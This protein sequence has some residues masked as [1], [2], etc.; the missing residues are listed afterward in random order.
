MYIRP[1]F[2]N[3]T[4]SYFIQKNKDRLDEN[5]LIDYDA[6]SYIRLM[7]LFETENTEATISFPENKVDQISLNESMNYH[8]HLRFYLPKNIISTVGKKINRIVIMF[9]G[10]NELEYFDFF[11]MIGEYFANNNVAAVLLPTPLNLNRRIKEDF[12]KRKILNSKFPTIRAKEGNE[13]LFFYS[14]VKTHKELNFLIK[15]IKGQTSIEDKEKEFGFYENYFAGKNTEITLLGYSLGG[16]KALTYFMLDFDPLKTE[17]RDHYKKIEKYLHDWKKQKFVSCITFNS[18][19]NL[20]EAYDERFFGMS[21]EDW[22]KLLMSS[23]RELKNRESELI[24]SFNI[25]KDLIRIFRFLYF[26]SDDDEILLYGKQKIVDILDHYLAVSG[27]SD[28]IVSMEQMKRFSHGG[29]KSTSG[30]K[31]EWEK[32]FNHI[33]AAGGDHFPGMEVAEWHELLP[34]IE[35]AILDFMDG[36][37]VRHYKK[38]KI[39][40]N[41]IN[42][43]NKSRYT[44]NKKD[45]FSTTHFKNI[46]DGLKKGNDKKDFKK[47]YY[48]SKAFYPNFKEVF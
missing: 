14:L 44:Y 34:R 46:L 4:V 32:W 27:G 21:Y 2:K 40:K 3:S 8:F 6:R 48:L 5:I 39:R 36:C 18:A 24:K 7:K 28:K 38:S 16:L 13:L 25:P 35:R 43:V 31:K 33:I 1:F 42:L 19:A 9:N 26:G 17:D 30:N 45:D 23:E 10:M 11:D 22:E 37:T 47:Y 20:L 12:N 41:L 15:K 29:K